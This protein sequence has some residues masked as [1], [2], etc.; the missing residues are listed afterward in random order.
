MRDRVVK[1]KFSHQGRARRAISETRPHRRIR[2]IAA[3]PPVPAS[4]PV[5]RGCRKLDGPAV[6][7][8]IW[9]RADLRKRGIDVRCS[10]FGLAASSCPRERET[11]WANQFPPRVRLAGWPEWNLKDHRADLISWP[12]RQTPE[13]LWGCATAAAC[14]NGDFAPFGSEMS[15]RTGKGYRAPERGTRVLRRPSGEG[16]RSGALSA[17]RRTFGHIA[18][19]MEG[20][21]C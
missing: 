13:G 1:I 2:A 19:L 7:R 3:T 20:R 8:P 9:E 12:A 11:E 5:P 10:R 18:V 14:S 6:G 4:F 17:P 21:A 15:R 16:E